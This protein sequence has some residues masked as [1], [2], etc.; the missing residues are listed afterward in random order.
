MT[1]LRVLHQYF[2]HAAQHYPDQIAVIEPGQGAITYHDLDLLSNRVRDR[3]AALGVHSGDRVGL[4]LRK[5]IDAVASILG[6]LKAG[7]AYTP[8]DPGAPAARNA[9]ILLNCAVKAAIVE[10]RFASKL[11]DECA[12]LGELPRLMSLSGTGGGEPL[13]E[14][15]DREDRIQLAG[16]GDSLSGFQ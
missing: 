12:A 14:A 8:V 9:Y 16:C 7:A 11:S 6:I 5:S 10:N 2:T 15:L 13:R 1:S 3:L 4:Y